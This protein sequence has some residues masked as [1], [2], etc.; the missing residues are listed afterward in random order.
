MKKILTVLL[1]LSVVFTYTVGTAFA[2]VGAGTAE[3]AAS[4]LIAAELE[5]V[6]AEANANG[7]YDATAVD[8]A[9]KEVTKIGEAKIADL[10][11]KNT[12]DGE[13]N[14]EAFIEAVQDWINAE[15]GGLRHEYEE[16]VVQEDYNIKLA[17]AKSTVEAVDPA[18]Y[19][20]ADQDKVK[21][22][23]EEVLAA[24]NE[25]KAV[26]DNRV[27]K[28]SFTSESGYFQTS[29]G[30]ADA[31]N[32]YLY[33]AEAYFSTIHT[34]DSTAKEWEDAIWTGFFGA[35]E[36]LTTVAEDEENNQVTDA[37][38]ENIIANITYW[39]KA[40]DNGYY[41]IKR[42]SAGDAVTLDDNDEIYGVK[43]ANKNKITAAEATEINDALMS[44]I[45]NTLEVLEVRIN[46]IADGEFLPKDGS[47][48]IKAQLGKL[49][50]FYTEEANFTTSI[51]KA[52][53][54]IEVYEAVVDYGDEMK[55][56]VSFSGAKL[57]DDADIDEA[58]ADAKHTIY[59]RFYEAD[60]PK[61]NFRTSYFASVKRID[62]PVEVAM[63]EAL[64]KWK[65]TLAD[66]PA[67]ADQKYCK[68]YYSN[69]KNPINWRAE[70]DQIKADAVKALVDVKSVE[71][72]DEIMAAADAKLAELRTAAEQ[73]N[74]FEKEIDKYQDALAEYA[75]EQWELVKAGGKYRQ[76][77]YNNGANNNGANSAL[78][79]G[80]TLLAS[81]K[82]IDAL[83]DAY[84]DAKAL[85][86]DIKTI[87]ELDTEADQV[88]D[89][90]AAL[91]A[92]ASMDKEADFTAAYDAY[93][94]YIANYGAGSV[95]VIG[96][97][98]LERR[99]VNLKDLQIKAVDDAIKALDDD[100]VITRDELTAV[101]EMYDKYVAYYAQYDEEFEIEQL[102]ALE[103]AQDKVWND[104]V[105]AV[106]DM[107]KKITTA[108]SIEDIQATQE[109]YDAL[110]GSQQRAVYEAYSYK[111]QLINSLLIKSVESLKLVK[112]HSTAGRTNGKS[113]IRIEWSTVGDDAAVDGY[114]IYKSTKKNSGYKHS[115]TTKNPANKWYK[116]TA[117]LKKGTRYYYK[118]RAFVEIDG[119]KY[120]SDWSNKA[121]R[122]AK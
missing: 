100:K 14:K 11:E 110:T 42:V 47:T 72:I 116:N 65:A 9:I 88:S 18:N 90:I 41:M 36:K 7:T 112:N 30:Y 93:Q 98:G 55:A 10:V 66:K 6:R 101:E 52:K 19:I 76:D 31:I 32:V 29:L 54:A 77:S 86:N 85:F 111:L 105:E 67:E 102:D 43:V 119:Q 94:A 106:K 69:S 96:A 48:T 92:T 80:E 89:L 37:Y 118:V 103:E 26:P 2:T 50:E 57:F 97:G 99:M 27:K 82:N 46:A 58:V 121:Y 1:A 62:D 28:L 20:E 109:A 3:D 49:L 34:A 59:S 15:T 84:N 25:V 81:A 35:L 12:D 38:V 70:Y 108:S 73:T 107:M 22:Y 115:F 71:E 16:I 24:L 8:N 61:D 5:K 113:W 39:A 114:E 23:K 68:D 13:L 78:K 4:K 56:E 60:Y 122:I 33:G 83:A 44:L 64:E 53:A 95:D 120:Y 17:A 40:A 87:E 21:D 45:N 74:A 51:G 63:N 79:A 91:P 75:E 117:G 104:E